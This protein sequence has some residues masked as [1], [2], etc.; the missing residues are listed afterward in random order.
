MNKGVSVS[1]QC[2]FCKIINKQIP[3]NIVHKDEHVVVFADIAPQAP[4]HLLIVPRL[5]IPSL[6]DLTEEHAHILGHI[7]LVAKALA[8]RFGLAGTGW[9]LVINC[10]E[11]AG[12]TVFHLHVHLLGGRPLVG[13]MA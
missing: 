12:Q 9:R 5:H 13:Q 8:E 1:D 6:N 4:T 10:G 3:S 11:G 2:V 7:S